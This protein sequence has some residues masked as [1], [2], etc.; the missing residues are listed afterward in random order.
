[1]H[2]ALRDH[3]AIAGK[4]GAAAFDRWIEVRHAQIE[5]GELVYIAHQLDFA[6]RI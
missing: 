5:R 2:A 4:Y 6:G 1:M 3:P